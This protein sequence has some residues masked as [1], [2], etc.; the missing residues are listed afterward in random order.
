MFARGDEVQ[1]TKVG[2]F[3]GK[4]AI[5]TDPFMDG[6]VKISMG[7]KTKSYLPNQ[8]GRLAICRAVLLVKV[9]TNTNS[10]MLLS[11]SFISRSKK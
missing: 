11:R 4:S 3:L 7:S 1:I 2:S 6:R 9:L 10:A 8:L 5:V